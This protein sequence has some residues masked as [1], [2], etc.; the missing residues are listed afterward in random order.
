MLSSLTTTSTKLYLRQMLHGCIMAV[1]AI[2][3]IDVV[4]HFNRAKSKFLAAS[5]AQRRATVKYCHILR[6]AVKLDD[7]CNDDNIDAISVAYFTQI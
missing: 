7:Y 2:A 3:A 6:I 1:V 5:C 4:M